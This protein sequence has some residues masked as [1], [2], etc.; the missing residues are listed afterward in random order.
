MHV[1]LIR[2]ADCTLPRLPTTWIMMRIDTF[3]VGFLLYHYHTVSL[4][5]LLAGGSLVDPA[6]CWG[7]PRPPLGVPPT[8]VAG[9]ASAMA[10]CAMSS[11]AMDVLVD[12]VGG[13][14]G[15]TDS[16]AARVGL[17]QID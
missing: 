4:L 12:V 16:M 10:L 14:E 13:Q 15:G 7:C 1:T 8:M 3:A 5:F 17:D 11:Q 2:H 9:A 6:T